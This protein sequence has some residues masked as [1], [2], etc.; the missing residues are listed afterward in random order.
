MTFE[1]WMKKQRITLQ[2]WQKKASKAFFEV[3]YNQRGVATGKT[4]LLEKMLAFVNL[5]GN[6]FEIALQKKKK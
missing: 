4:F 6:V 5:H 1:Q 3:L 2:P